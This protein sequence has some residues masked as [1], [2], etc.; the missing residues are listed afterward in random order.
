MYYRLMVYMSFSI[1]MP[2]SLRNQMVYIRVV[3]G[4]KFREYFLEECA[5]IL[6]SRKPQAVKVT[7][8]GIFVNPIKPQWSAGI[9]QGNISVDIYIIID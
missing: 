6:E 7:P 4:F 9:T 8:F 2:C 3:T 1:V 5:I